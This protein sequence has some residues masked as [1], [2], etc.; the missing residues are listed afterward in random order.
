MSPATQVL[1]RFAAM[2]GQ[3]A[4]IASS[5]HTVRLSASTH[6]RALQRLR[7]LGNEMEQAFILAQLFLVVTGSML[8]AGFDGGNQCAKE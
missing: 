4:A 3:D 7:L 8:C 5:H 1:S 2:S 6:Q